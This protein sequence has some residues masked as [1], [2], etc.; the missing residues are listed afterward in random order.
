[1]RNFAERRETSSHRHAVRVERAAVE[2]LVAARSDPYRAARAERSQWQ[3]AADG[4]SRQ[5]MSGF[6]PKNSLAPPQAS[7]APVLTSSKISNAPFLL[8][9]S[10][11][12]EEA[13]LRETETDVHKDG[14]RMI[15]QFVPDAA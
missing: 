6:T 10:R 11:S 5:I 3:A 12:P 14:S 13:G 2:D 9:I 8:Q 7:L 1:V 15:A 4:L